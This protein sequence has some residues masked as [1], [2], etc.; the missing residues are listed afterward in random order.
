MGAIFLAR[1][2]LCKCSDHSL[3]DY[4]RNHQ[5][6]QQHFCCKTVFIHEILNS[7]KVFEN[8][9][10]KAWKTCVVINRDFADVRM[11]VN[12][13]L[14]FHYASLSLT[15]LVMCIFHYE[16]V[17]QFSLFSSTSEQK[18][19]KSIS[20][21]PIYISSD[22]ALLRKLMSIVSRWETMWLA[23]QLKKKSRKT[24]YEKQLSRIAPD[25]SGIAEGKLGE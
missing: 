3:H 20:I 19:K 8:P 15:R 21:F 2:P 18:F 11:F 23:L 22:P 4:I 7:G 13:V 17:S 25:R 5:Q 9:A 6:R 24:L 16:I 14:R 10:Q 12:N 1:S